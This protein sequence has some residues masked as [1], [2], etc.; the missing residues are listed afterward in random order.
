MGPFSSVETSALNN[1]AMLNWMQGLGMF[2]I[3]SISAHTMKG[4]PAKN[5]QI[6]NQFYNLH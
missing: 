6:Q 3:Y 1:P 2:S 4:T 5:I